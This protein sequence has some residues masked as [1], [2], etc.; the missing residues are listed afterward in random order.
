[1]RLPDHFGRSSDAKNPVNAEKVKCDGRTDGP[2]DQQT[3]EPTKRG[4]ELRSIR[5]KI[6]SIFYHTDTHTNFLP[7]FNITSISSQKGT[8]N[9]AEELETTDN[10][11]SEPSVLHLSVQMTFEGVL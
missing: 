6:S 11:S 10:T 5:L 7:N 8:L 9:A 4:V 1:M 2:T 3:N